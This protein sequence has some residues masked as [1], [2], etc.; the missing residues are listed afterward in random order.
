MKIKYVYPIRYAAQQ[1]GLSTHVIRVWEKRYQAVVPKRTDTNRRVFCRRDIER[2]KMLKTAVRVGNSISQIAGLS[3]EEL[4]QLVKLDVSDA[5]K[6]SAA[7]E[8]GS[9]D[10][11]YFYDRSLSAV[12]NFDAKALESVLD[13]AAVHLSKLELIKAVIEPLC[14]KIG[15]LWEHGELKVINEHMTTTVIRSFLW[16]LLRSAEVSETSPKIVIATPAGHQHELGALALALIACETNWQSLYFGPSLPAE[17]IAAAVTYADARAVA[18]SITYHEDSHQLN[19]EI[20]KLRRY[21]GDGITIF[22]GGQ[23]AWPLADFFDAP[24]I[25]ILKD[26]DSFRIAIDNLRKLQHG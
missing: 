7:R 17:E 19:L 4:M 1:T 11:T 13:R 22:I 15:E 25:Q 3:S 6:V 14:Q 10:T 8:P 21:L 26:V 23:G 24:E 20:K 5:S 18:L 2:L 16:N 12:L 9:L